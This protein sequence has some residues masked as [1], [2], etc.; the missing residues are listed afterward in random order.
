MPRS[1]PLRWITAVVPLA[2][3][4]TLVLAAAAH[5]GSYSVYACWPGQHGNGSWADASTS[6]TTNGGSC[7][8]SGDAPPFTS[9]YHGL[10]ARHDVSPYAQY[11]WQG[12]KLNIG[13]PDGGM[14]ITGIEADWR[15]YCG[16]T[17]WYPYL[18]AT[19]SG[20][21]FRN[22][23]TWGFALTGWNRQAIGGMWEPGLTIGNICSASPNCNRWVNPPSQVLAKN[24]RVDFYDPHMPSIPEAHGELWNG[25]IWQ[26]GSR[27][28]GFSGSDNIG[29]KRMEFWV[30]DGVWHKISETATNEGCNYAYTR[31]CPQGK[32]WGVGHVDTSRFTDGSRPVKLRVYDAADN[33]TDV[34]ATLHFDNTAPGKPAAKIDSLMMDPS[35]RGF[36][37]TPQGTQD[38]GW[39]TEGTAA[40]AWTNPSGGASGLCSNT[41]QIRPVGGSVT[42]ERVRNTN[43]AQT[44]TV[45]GLANG[46]YEA[47]VQSRDC[48]GGA[49]DWSDWVPFGVDT[50]TPGTAD[51][52]R[53]TGV[54]VNGW[55]NNTTAI[56]FPQNARMGVGQEKLTGLAGIRGYSV[57]VQKPGQAAANPD[58][59]LADPDDI[60]AITDGENGTLVIG[61][62]PEGKTI[63]KARAIAGNGRAAVG[64][65]TIEL[66]A[67]RTVPDVTVNPDD[68]GAVYTDG[69]VHTVTGT[70]AEAPAPAL[71]DGKSGMEGS[72][73]NQPV[74]AGGHIETQVDGAAVTKTRGP[75]ATSS[76][77]NGQH[78]LTYA[79]VDAAGNRS[80]VKQLGFTVSGDQDGDGIPDVSD[81]C[82]A[83]AGPAPTG[84]PSG[85]GDGS[86][87][88][89]TIVGGGG[90]DTIVNAANGASKNGVD[91]L[92][93]AKV[94]DLYFVQ[95][96]KDET[97]KQRRCQRK[98]GTSKTRRAKCKLG[99]LTKLTAY[100][101]RRASIRGKLV[102]SKGAPVVNARIQVLESPKGRGIGQIDKGGV[103]TRADGTF[104]Y[105]A[106]QNSTTRSIQ[107]VYKPF[108][109]QDLTAD[110]Q[111]VDL[112]IRAKVRATFTVRQGVVRY[113]GVALPGRQMV[114]IQGRS[115]GGRWE[116]IASR[117]SSKTGRFSG[118]YKLKQ[119]TGRQ[120]QLRARVVSAD[121]SV[122]VGT[123]R[124]ARRTAR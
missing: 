30:H 49:S 102:D 124:V 69:V 15:V 91:A 75:V 115:A 32:G 6:E 84:C 96:H 116:T 93:G 108:T 60:N 16:N 45:T 95:K 44:D 36:V 83:V 14:A 56:D 80:T 19:A 18:A 53:N 8:P 67:D 103:R 26:R 85:G 29:I 72:G 86:S 113:S 74:E 97:L 82:P 112:T 71:A 23:G 90:G 92:R 79:A 43:A 31:P 61:E 68:P 27:Y 73:S 98:A 40:L 37:A 58:N 20:H 33:M 39:Q 12:A 120:I 81:Q 59:D 51:L 111:K 13:I 9:E 105:T 121:R 118:R 55:I 99:D 17:G 50:R 35:R 1:N 104:R 5:A 88:T 117:R 21:N 52:P 66:R 70:D 100:Y 38:T 46:R 10:Q 101:G 64:Y 54:E 34:D 77:P 62:I 48:A 78:T 114:Q 25:S 89:T 65:A 123:S 109:G 119:R 63:V 110:K 87:L 47:R 11:T 7:N 28:L 94:K 106:A 4:A 107:F 42:V 2:L 122:L 24:I 41:L 76:S 22:C 57:T 3:L